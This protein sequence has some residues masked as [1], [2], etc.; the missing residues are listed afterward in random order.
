[1]NN[2]VLSELFG[3]SSTEL[4]EART[5]GMKG[6]RYFQDWFKSKDIGAE[7]PEC[8]QAALAICDFVASRQMLDGGIGTSWN[9][10]GTLHQQK[11]L[12]GAWFVLPLATAHQVTG[13]HLYHVA[14]VR[15]FSYYYREFQNMGDDF[16]PH[17][18][19][20][21]LIRGAI[22]LY[23]TTGFDKYLT[24]AE[25]AAQRLTHED[26]AKENERI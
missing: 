17:Q 15:A 2:T 24:M 4:I 1:M 20:A 23:Q 16:L 25:E 21:P 18:V 14:S 11:G 9:K 5:L 26:D 10:D 3:S 7:K 8:K 12:D 6:Y 22:M 19:L 13:K